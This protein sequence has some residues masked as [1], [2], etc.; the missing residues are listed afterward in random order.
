MLKHTICLWNIIKVF[1][2][3]DNIIVSVFIKRGGILS[4][5][6]I[7][8]AGVSEEPS[9]KMLRNTD[10]F[11][12]KLIDH[13]D[14]IFFILGGYWG[15]MK[16]FADKALEKNYTVIF[17]LPSNP[18]TYPPNRDNT[19]VINT[20]LD[21]PTRST[22]LTRSSDILVV[23][24]GRI[25]S[26]IEALLAYSYG[27]PVVFIESGYETDRLQNCFDEYF[28]VRETARI[29]R[30]RDGGEAAEHVIEYIVMKSRSIYYQ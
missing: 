11:L 5:T 30:A 10:L 29:H 7:G 9:N 27:R 1:G 25:G 12:E 8:I 17:I 4:K 22:V 20:S 13:R 16:Y 26:M 3:Y 23:F 15:F 28:D 24:G 18:H 2:R 21:Y 14:K 19:V 6:Y